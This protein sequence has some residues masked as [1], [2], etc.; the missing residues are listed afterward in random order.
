MNDG[1]RRI[2]GA[3]AAADSVAHIAF[4]SL[5]GWRMF[6]GDD[7]GR[8]ANVPLI[9]VAFIGLAAGTLGWLLERYG[10]K[11]KLGRLG[12]WGV[13]LSTALAAALLFFASWMG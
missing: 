6:R 2:A 7:W 10:G 1:L 11:T 8:Y 12:F 9:I 5:F 13:A 3:L 4:L